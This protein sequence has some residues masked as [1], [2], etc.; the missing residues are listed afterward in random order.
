MKTPG[1][2]Q[3]FT[4]LTY[5]TQFQKVNQLNVLSIL[6]DISMNIVKF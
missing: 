4:N 1:E 6:K 5:S 3:Q 2:I